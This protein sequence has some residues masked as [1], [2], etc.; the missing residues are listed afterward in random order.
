[1]VMVFIEMAGSRNGELQ[2]KKNKSNVGKLGMN[3]AL[4]CRPKD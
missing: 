2:K 1:M 3:A 4:G